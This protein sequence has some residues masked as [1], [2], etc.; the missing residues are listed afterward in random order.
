M[1]STHGAPR[2]FDGPAR[3]G[4]EMSDICAYTGDVADDPKPDEA[5]RTVSI[6]DLARNASGVVAAVARTGRPALVTRHGEPL[7]A[8]VP[9]DPADLEDLILAKA[10][11]YLSDLV[12][13]EED[14][15]AGRTRPASEVFE[16]LDP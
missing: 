2:R 15:G 1:G 3:P 16:E 9:V 10:P 12:A 14:L 7:A 11:E 4:R 13:A 8:V 5:M 6:R